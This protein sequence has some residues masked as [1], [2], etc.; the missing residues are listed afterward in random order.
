MAYAQVLLKFGYELPRGEIPMVRRP[1][2]FDVSSVP[3]M[4]VPF[5]WMM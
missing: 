1:L 4:L 5:Q 2:S 3:L